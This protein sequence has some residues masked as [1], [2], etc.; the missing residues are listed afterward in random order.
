MFLPHFCWNLLEF[1]WSRSLQIALQTLKPIQCISNFFSK[2]I[3]APCN[4]L[5]NIKSILKLR[6]RYVSKKFFSPVQY[7]YKHKL[8]KCFHMPE[9]ERIFPF[10]FFFFS[11]SSPF[12]SFCL[13]FIYLFFFWLSSLEKCFFFFPFTVSLLLH[14]QL[15][16][17][18]LNN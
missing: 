5:W 1:F 2:F 17:Q 11:F 4:K 15:T 10:L 7:K 14:Q 18:R 16:T 3:L 9:K 8:S 6:T 13:Y 12:L